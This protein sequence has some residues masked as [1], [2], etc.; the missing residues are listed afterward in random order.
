MTRESK[1]QG[2]RRIVP[3]EQRN[4]LTLRREIDPSYAKRIVFEAR[5]HTRRRL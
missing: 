4:N 5:G 2:L 1:G 3:I